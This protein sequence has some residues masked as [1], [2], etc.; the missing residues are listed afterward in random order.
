MNVLVIA[1][2]PDDEV[3]GCGGTIARH[4]AEGADVS[5]CVVT[6]GRPP[7]FSK[8]SIDKVWRESSEAH[9]FLGVK[10]TISLGFP[11]A[12]IESR[13]RCDLNSRLVEV[14][15][16]EKPD[17]LYTPHFADMQKDHRLVTE[18]VMVAIRPKY[19][20]KVKEVYMYETLSETEW[21]I[22]HPG[23]QFA[24]NYYVDISGYLEVKEKAFMIYESQCSGFPNPR[25]VDAIRSLSA[26]RGSN[27]MVEAAEAFE[28]VRIIWER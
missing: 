2:H 4:V 19:S 18:A 16:A 17:V 14:I 3:L 15:Q 26:Y 8:E 6:K 20:H 24:P 7:L 13:P 9:R 5:V 25:S 12:E 27:V 28:V 21:N 10:K 1:P 23:N 22:P 11:A